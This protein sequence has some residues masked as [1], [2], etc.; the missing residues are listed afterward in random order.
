MQCWKSERVLYASRLADCTHNKV[1]IATSTS[2]P[3]AH[4]TSYSHS[5]I[6][7]QAASIGDEV[8]TEECANN[9]SKNDYSEAYTSL[10]ST[11]RRREVP[12]M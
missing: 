6:D 5:Q 10:Q 3:L 8:R 11:L 7:A 2:N 1:C 12:F 9:C 4:E